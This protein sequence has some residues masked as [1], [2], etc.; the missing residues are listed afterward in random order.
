MINIIIN[1]N[2][3]HGFVI[4]SLFFCL[5]LLLQFSCIEKEDFELFE[6]EG[7]IVGFHPCSV[8]HSYRIGFVIISNDFSDTIATYSLSPNEF[9]MP[10]PVGLN[11]KRPLYSIPEHEFRYFRESAYFPEFL[12]YPDSLIINYPIKVTYRKALENERPSQ[13]CTTDIIR[14]DFSRQWVNNHVIVIKASRN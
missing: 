8:N 5:M 14:S 2:T 11:P 10:A 13:I 3:I 4:K 6:M 1:I 7:F 9:K 12:Y